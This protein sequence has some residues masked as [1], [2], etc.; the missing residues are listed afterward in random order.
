MFRPNHSHLQ[1][2]LFDAEQVLPEKYRD[3]LLHSWAHTFRQEV[4]ARIDETILAP[5][6]SGTHSRPNAPIN[7]L[8][9]AEILRSG[10]GWSDRELHDHVTF[11]L[12][13]RHALGIDDLCE[14]VF[15]LRTLYNFRSRIREHA[16]RQGENLFGKLFARVTD[17]QLEALKLKTQWQRMDST[18]LLSNLARM[19]RLELIVSVV[20]TLYGALASGEQSR[21]SEAVAFYVRERAQR[22]CYGIKASETEAHLLKLGEI[23]LAWQREA[24]EGEL[25]GEGERAL[26]WRVLREQ[27]EVEGVS[28]VRLREKEEVESTSLQSVHDPEASYRVKSGKSYRGGYVASLSE[29]CDPANE[30]QLITHVEVAP[31][32]SDDAALLARTLDDLSERGMPIEKVT[33]DGGYTGPVAETACARHGVEHRP[34]RMRG[35]TGSPERFGWEHYEWH[36]PEPGGAPVA[37]TCPEGKRG[38]VREGRNSYIIHFEEGLCQGCPFFG[39]RCRVKGRRKG[40]GISITRRAVEVAMA[41]GRICPE[42][43][44]L[45]SAVESTVRSLKHPFAGGK[46]PVRGLI[47]ATMVILAS[48]MMVNALRIHRY[49]LH[50]ALKRLFELFL[51]IIRRQEALLGAL[52]WSRLRPGQMSHGHDPWRRPCASRPCASI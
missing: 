5:L 46:L 23:L 39:N 32:Q 41:R 17:D 26:L 40:S 31:N 14:E 16:A 12:Q 47:P 51:R 20:A 19:S 4:F 52:E 15:E 36:R 49:R 50:R 42:D 22:V 28:S 25:F 6:Y 45:R 18:Q 38:S 48:A 29:T 37:L 2:A 7:V 24:L 8:V 11:D 30:L 33:T 10:F 13:V 27:Y 43:G 9:G 21:W 44:P 34:T 35:G 1:H 3:R